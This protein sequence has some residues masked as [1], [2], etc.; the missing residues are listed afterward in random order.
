MWPATERFGLRTAPSRLALVQD[1]LNTDAPA[2]RADPDDL[3]ADAAGATRWA[4]GALG[5]PVLTDDDA[6]HLRAFRES[7]RAAVRSPGATVPGVRVAVEAALSGD[8]TVTVQPAGDGW[9]YVVGAVLLAADEARLTGEWHRLKV[10]RND[11][12]GTA[13]YDRSRNS[14]AVW[15][16][17]ARCG[18]A[19]N[20]RASRARRR[21]S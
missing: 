13:F 6:S 19:P 3:L 2:G 9:R 21:D 16:D 8:G 1:L 18:N 5:G 4:A 15:H 14:S 20:L 17:A 11:A 12:C 10:C 7:L